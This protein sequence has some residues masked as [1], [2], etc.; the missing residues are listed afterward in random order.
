[1]SYSAMSVI[2]QCRY[3]V[4]DIIRH[5]DTI[6]SYV[7]ITFQSHMSHTKHTHPLDIHIH[8]PVTRQYTEEQLF[9]IPMGSPAFL[10]FKIP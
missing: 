8:Q 2:Y 7:S 4:Q 9:Q 3:M 10:H 6:M 5:Y 1:M